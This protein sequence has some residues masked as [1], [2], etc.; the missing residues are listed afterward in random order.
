M[1]LCPVS[2]LIS[3]ICFCVGL[4]PFLA[5]F[6]LLL[7]GLPLQAYQRE[8]GQ[9]DDG[10]GSGCYN[11]SFRCVDSLLQVSSAHIF[12]EA[13]CTTRSEVLSTGFGPCR[14]WQHQWYFELGSWL[15]CFGDRPQSRSWE[16]Q[17]PN[18]TNKLTYNFYSFENC[19]LIT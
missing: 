19:S 6:S 9:C 2:S 14:S 4:F 13:V 18:K 10:W 12:D 5:R 16:I 1:R 11:Q 8:S 15:S 3:Q 7:L 17:G